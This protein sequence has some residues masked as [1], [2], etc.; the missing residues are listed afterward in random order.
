MSFFSLFI[1]SFLNS[2]VGSTLVWDITILGWEVTYGEEFVPNIEGSYTI[3][4]QETNKMA[5]DEKPVRNSF[6]IR[7]LGKV[8]LTIENT[9][10]KK[11]RVVYRTKFKCE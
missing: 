5:A 2:Q 10:S 1:V 7:E 9:S 4:I 3:L 11:K 8:T 6:K